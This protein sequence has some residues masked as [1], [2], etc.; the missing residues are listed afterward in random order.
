MKPVGSNPPEYLLYSPGQIVASYLVGTAI[1]ANVLMAINYRRLGLR[2]VAWSTLGL[3]VIATAADLVAALAWHRP[4]LFSILIGLGGWRR[5][6][7]DGSLYDQHTAAGGRRA[8]SWGAVG[9]ALMAFVVLVVLFELSTPAA[10]LEP[11]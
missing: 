7:R 1:G 8:S 11:R 6:M 9:L 5:A 10:L 4:P 2:W 3:A